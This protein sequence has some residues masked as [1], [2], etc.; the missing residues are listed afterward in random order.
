MKMRQYLTFRKTLLV[1]ILLALSTCKV[2]FV[3]SYDE[4]IDNGLKEYKED[5]NTFVKNMI[6]L[7]GTQQG[8]YEANKLKYNEL[9]S[10]IDL[11]I[12][13]AS[14]H[15]T[16]SCR[17]T[18]DLSEK[19]INIMGEK[20][21]PEVMPENQSKKGNSYGCTERLLILIRD[22]L[23]VLK[24]IHENTDKCTDEN[25]NQISCIR[26]ATGPIIMSISNQSIDA[27]WVVE[28]TK[29]TSKLK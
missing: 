2:Q 22:Q 25:G 12:D 1:G 26:S 10:K 9:E 4:V 24:E 15:S 11:L 19:I 17:L 14:L 5:L 27:A 13:R 3:S 7:G 8:T 18:T 16:G 28:T 6:D 23:V 29:K 21:P 20:I